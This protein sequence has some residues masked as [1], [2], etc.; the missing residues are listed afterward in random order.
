MSI[1]LHIKIV[2]TLL[3]YKNSENFSVIIFSKLI[4]TS[5]KFILIICCR[6]YLNVWVDRRY[7]VNI[8]FR[9]CYYALIF[10]I[11]YFFNLICFTVMCVLIIFNWFILWLLF[12]LSGS[13]NIITIHAIWDRFNY[14]FF[15][16]IIIMI[17]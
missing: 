3:F 16:Y 13:N 4:I 2:N 5:C 7:G 12:Y 14:I 15:L 11:C 9:S 17:L 6:I 8:S 10:W 1:H